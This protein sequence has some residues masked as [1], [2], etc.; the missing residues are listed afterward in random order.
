MCGISKFPPKPID[1]NE[2]TCLSDISLGLAD[3]D[4]HLMTNSTGSHTTRPRLLIE[5][6][7]PIAEIGIE[8]VRER[9]PMTPFPAPNRLHVWWARRPLVASRA[10]I[11]ASLLPADADRQKFLHVLGIHGDP[12]ASK[13]RIAEARR[14][15]ERFEGNAYSYKR[16]F[17]YTPSAE[18]SRWLTAEHFKL[19]H[20]EV[21]TVLDPT[22]GVV[23]V[24]IRGK[25]DR[26]DFAFQWSYGEMAPTITG[27]GYDWTIEQ[28]GKA[29]EELIGFTTGM[30][31]NPGLFSEQRKVHSATITYGSGD[32][33]GIA[34]G[35][36]DCIV[37][38][39]PY[40]ANVMYAELSDFFYVWLKRT[41]GILYPE[42]F[43]SYLTDKDREAVANPAKFKGHKGGAKNLAVK[44][45][46]QRMS[47]I[48][49]E[50]R[51]VLT[52]GGVMTVMFTHKAS[53][54]W[55]ALANGLIQAGFV[56]TASWPI[57]TESDGSLHIKEKSAAKSTIFLVCRPRD[58]RLTDDVVYWEEVEPQVMAKVRERVQEFQ[59]AG[60]GGVDLYLA[61]FG[62]ALQVFSENWPLKRGRPV[63]MP[64]KTKLAE[65]QEWD[66]YAVNPEDALDAARREVKRW[67]MEQ[68]ATV[69]R[70]HHLDALTEWY[71][72]A[73]DAFKAPRF[74]S[75][76]AL[77]LA[78]VVGLDFDKDVK[79]VVCEVKSSDV[80]LWDSKTRFA[81]SKLGPVG[82]EVM[83]DTL[84]HAALIGREQNTGAAQAVLEKAGL[85]K[86]STLLT[87]MEALLNVLPAPGAAAGK[88]KDDSLGGA[89]SD[90]EALEKLRR[91]AFSEEIPQ[92]KFQ[93]VL[94]DKS[95]KDDEED[96]EE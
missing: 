15:G 52:R 57:N 72:L 46:Q 89:A 22:A 30:N 85:L 23:R 78:R 53:G 33:L 18:E 96:G 84:H 3:S 95:T 86:D 88:K 45:Y 26:H 81:K 93:L 25:F 64:K 59:E 74:P 34:D 54:A 70:Q 47:D 38:D 90:C 94:F 67:R 65:G 82:E 48:F 58:E 39:P 6:W 27:L 83:L 24:A 80:I 75:D 20:V 11:L 43:S 17:T 31:G 50:C 16:A 2:R 29:V 68:L 91:L 35:T 4:G 36:I 55:D 5:E 79:N 60:I 69:K 51:R 13:E 76:E 1:R 87:A 12:M 71:V 62:P 66:P 61:C 40:E 56:I 44:D 63:Q 92:P 37:M 42:Q 21:P 41:A 14:T 32:S 9:T 7:L 49:A 10:A 73:W 19:G 8:S 77:K 28:T